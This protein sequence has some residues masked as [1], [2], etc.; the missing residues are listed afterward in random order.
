M[1]PS[2]SPDVG[3]ELSDAD[4]D[5]LFVLADVAVRRGLAGESPPNVDPARLAP[6]LRERVGAFVTLEVNGRL[7]GCIGSIAPTEP[8]GV[9]VPTLAWSAAFADPR[10]PRLTAAD[11]PSLHIKLS[12]LGPLTPIPASSEAALAGAL[13]PGVDGVLL[14]NG[15]AHATFLPAVW[16]KLPDPSAFLHA[17]EAKAGLGRGEWRP[18]TEAWRYTAKEYQRAAAEIL[19]RRSRGGSDSSA[20]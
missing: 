10:L 11:Y 6:A 17:L 8:L 13:R 18:G 5:T 3:P 1:E 14:R 4:V 19:R 2:P 7:N 20:A 9:V 15:H 12:L 16:E